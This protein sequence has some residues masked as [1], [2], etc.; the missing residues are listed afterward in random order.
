AEGP[1]G[2]VTRQINDRRSAGALGRAL[3][4]D[5]F[6]AGSCRKVGALVE[7][8]EKSFDTTL[9]RMG[10]ARDREAGQEETE[11]AQR[12]D[13]ESRVAALQRD[14]GVEAEQGQPAR[15]QEAVR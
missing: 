11:F 12:R 2:L 14:I 7:A 4:C 9:Q 3:T 1:H 6:A 15:P 10:Q 5:R 8:A 13:A